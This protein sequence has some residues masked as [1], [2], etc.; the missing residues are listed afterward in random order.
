MDVTDGQTD[1][2]TTYDSSP[3]QPA[4]ASDKEKDGLELDTGM[5]GGGNGVDILLLANREV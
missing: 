2:R 4:L 3:A 1:R 5:G